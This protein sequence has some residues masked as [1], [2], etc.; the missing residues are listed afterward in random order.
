MKI[1]FEPK[2]K[3]SFE[4][5]SQFKFGQKVS[6]K[7]FNR[8]S[9]S[10]KSSGSGSK[11]GEKE[12]RF[13]N[14]KNMNRNSLGKFYHNYFNMPPTQKNKNSYLG[15][16]SPF[17]VSSEM[18]SLKH[19]NQKRRSL[20]DLKSKYNQ[21]NQKGKLMRNSLNKNSNTKKNYD[22]LNSKFPLII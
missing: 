8:R 18:V 17:F 2:I 13:M 6:V 15:K 4:K 9:N 20:A 10:K 12:I 16:Q 21:K 11:M 3:K 7:D 5:R 22:S 14:S 19:L 1:Q